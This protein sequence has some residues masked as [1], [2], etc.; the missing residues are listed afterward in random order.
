[1]A[2]KSGAPKGAKAPAKKRGLPARSYS[3]TTVK[4]LFTFAYNQCAEPTCNEPIIADA[5]KFSKE[6]VIGQIAHIY[7]HSDGGPRS[8]PGLTKKERDGFDNTMLFCPTHHVKVDKQ[9]ET[10]PATLLIEWKEQ[11]RRKFAAR[12]SATMADIGYPELEI[13]AKA[14]LSSE[15]KPASSLHAI[16]PKEKIK[17][18]G[19]TQ[20][21]ETLITM[22]SAKSAEVA[23]VLKNAAQLDNNFPHRLREG[24]V[25]QYK[26]LYDAGVRG[27]Q[28][29][30]ELYSWA[31]GRP[32]DLPRNGAGLCILSHLFIL[33]DVF[34][35]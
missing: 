31:A 3:L 29:F 17:K 18:N 25:E 8:K 19:L 7:A 26:K 5:T 6:K 30:N 12:M 9:E 32:G 28:L 35:K 11:H 14:L 15:P 20:D 24:F 4:L 10:Y 1:M 22:G 34:E 2:K 21:S 13:A 33:C 27:D 16:P 23:D